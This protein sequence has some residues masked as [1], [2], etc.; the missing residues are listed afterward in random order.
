MAA[1]E[2][3]RAGISDLELSAGGSI[4]KLACGDALYLTQKSWRGLPLQLI[5]CLRYQ[6]RLWC[7]SSCE[8]LAV[9]TY[10]IKNIGLTIACGR[11]YPC[12]TVLIDLQ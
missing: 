2:V 9:N 3:G 5:G 4:C 1:E 6:I 8:D 11:P 10:C 12:S 7:S